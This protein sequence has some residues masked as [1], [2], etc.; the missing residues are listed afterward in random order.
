MHPGCRR[1]GIQKVVLLPCREFFCLPS[2][3]Y[4]QLGMLG[5]CEPVDARYLASGGAVVAEAIEEV[6]W[7][8]NL[9]RSP[10][11]WRRERSLVTTMSRSPITC[12]GALNSVE[13][14]HSWHPVVLDSSTGKPAEGVHIILQVLEESGSTDIF[15][16]LA[17]GLLYH[18]LPAIYSETVCRITNGDGRCI[19]L[20]PPAGSREAKQEETDLITGQTY[21]IIFKTKEYFERTERD[22]FYPW[23]EVSWSHYVS[24]V[25]Q[26]QFD[27][28]LS[29]SSLLRNITTFLYWSVHTDLQ[30]TE[31]ARLLATLLWIGDKEGNNWDMMYSKMSENVDAGNDSQMP[32]DW[33]R[34]L[35]SNVWGHCHIVSLWC[36]FPSWIVWRAARKYPD[37]WSFPRRPLW[38]L[39]GNRLTLNH[40]SIYLCSTDR[41]RSARGINTAVQ[42]W[43]NS[44]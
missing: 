7:K 12:H 21:K 17:R 39:W 6:T 26:R 40:K 2:K 30:R 38:T 24:V 16:P 18:P 43:P 11:A 31:E 33:Y 42:P 19:D 22:S 25:R 9:W 3:S 35:S 37:S 28:Y 10:P 29:Q 14:W 1:I 36:C 4:I 32:Y 27:R 41:L 13:S 20:L 5:E 34:D 23:V 8:G 15:H 44:N